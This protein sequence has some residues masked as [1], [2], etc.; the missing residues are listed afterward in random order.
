MPDSGHKTG[1]WKS[2]FSGNRILLSVVCLILGVVGMMQYQSLRKS[3]EE[4]FIE[5]KTISQL[6]ADSILLYRRQ[7]DLKARQGD[8]QSRLQ[9]LE[10]AKSNDALLMVL[11]KQDVD[12]ARVKAGFTVVQ[13]EGLSL[14][15]PA[16]SAVSENMLTQLVNELKASDS[17][18][19]AING[20]R[21]A[22]TTEI[23]KTDSGF[24]V[25]GIILDA[26]SPITILACGPRMEMY[27]SLRMIGG[28]LDRWEQQHVDV[29]VEIETDLVIPALR[30][31]L[32]D[33]KNPYMYLVRE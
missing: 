8:L 24:S 21:V 29:R 23:R 32:Q 12:A 18:A 4:S 6:A 22:A 14:L 15:I 31:E 27:S 30:K 5:G 28:V 26:K 1:R 25:N 10:V 20:E 3:P 9:D 16:N 2:S 19:I 13:G 7:E 33:A 11:T 17:H